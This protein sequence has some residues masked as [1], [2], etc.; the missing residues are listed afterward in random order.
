MKTA[1]LLLTLI[2]SAGSLTWY[3]QDEQARPCIEDWAN[4]TQALFTDASQYFRQLS[5]AKKPVIEEDLLD[6]KLQELLPSENMDLSYHPQADEVQKA[7]TLALDKSQ[8]GLLPN[9]FN[10]QDEASTSVSG[11]VHMDE[12][13]NIIGAEVQVAIPTNM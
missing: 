10:K 9:L 12:D 2:L 13:D 11:K 6:Q 1:L 5:D 4:H 7:T 3:L 8:N